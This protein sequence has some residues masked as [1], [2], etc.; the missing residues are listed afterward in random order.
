MKIEIII[1]IMYFNFI[2][3]WNIYKYYKINLFVDLFYS[4]V[5]NESRNKKKK[6]NGRQSL[7]FF[8]FVS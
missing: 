3:I 7:Y 1:I 6:K 5:N 8:I 4:S 2:T